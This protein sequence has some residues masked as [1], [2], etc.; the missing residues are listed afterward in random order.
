M[1]ADQRETR[2]GWKKTLVFS[3]LPACVLLAAIE[4][5]AR[6]LEWYAPPALI[7]AG[8]G[9]TEASRLFLEDPEAPGTLMTAPNKTLK[10][11]DQHLFRPQR[12]LRE[13]PAGV[14][15]AFFL[16]GSSVNYL[17][18]EL[19]LLEERLASELDAFHTVEIINCGGLSYGSHRLVLIAAEV[20]QYAP[21]LLLI[22][23][24]HNEFEELE[25][26]KL[27]K[28]WSAPLQDL[29]S[30]AAV[31][32]I[33]RDRMTALQVSRLQRER[34][35]RILEESIP[36]SSRAWGY[37]FSDQELA[38]RMN[39]YQEN[40]AHI[41]EM[42][43]NRGVRT[44]IGTVP[45]NL[46]RPALHGEPGARY[47]AEVL[48]MFAAG[49][50]EAGKERAQEILSSVPRHQSSS[51]EN[52]IIREAARH[53]SALADVEEAVTAREPHGVPGETLFGD[54]CHLNP[55]GNSILIETFEQAILALFR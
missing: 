39:T 13:K 35:A 30:H 18:Y 46:V 20:L 25:Q 29:L 8:Q 52:A 22:Y 55:E 36:D 2:L 32:R 27:A 21:D 4:G 10:V 42:A 53:A 37:A 3:L 16:G 28:P 17:D 6:L 31:F 51:A 24:G 14:L 43:R 49:N 9:F 11:H 45:S 34:N 48:P 12:F 44:V 38:Q 41:L 5:S 23:S 26:F 40:L 47:E 50:H 19:P 54:H 1:I 15:R 7:D 33:I